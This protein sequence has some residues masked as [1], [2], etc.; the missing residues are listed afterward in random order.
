MV[1]H[2]A[3]QASQRSGASMAI[4]IEGVQELRISESNLSDDPLCSSKH[5][6]H[7]A[8]E[9][10]C[11]SSHHTGLIPMHKCS[12]SAPL[13]LHPDCVTPRFGL[14]VRLRLRIG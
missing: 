5:G 9:Q 14:R 11:F 3:L 7:A 1:R 10:N 6:T 13:L 2:R 12:H 8:H 4:E